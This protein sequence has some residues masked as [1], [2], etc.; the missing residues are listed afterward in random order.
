MPFFFGPKGREYVYHSDRPALYLVRRGTAPGT[1]DTALKEQ[2]LARGVEIRFKHK[3]ERL[4]RGGVV[5]HGPRRPNVISVGYVFETDTADGVFAALSDELAPKGYAYLL[6]HRGRGTVASCMFEDFHEEKVFVE[7][8]VEFF[9]RNVGFEMKASRRFGGLGNFYWVDTARH[10]TL[11][12]AGEAAG[13]QDALWGFGLRYAMVSGSLAARAAV[14]GAPETYDDLWERRFG[15]LL[16]ASA[17]NRFVYELM[18]SIGYGKLLRDLDRTSDVRA[19][20][21]RR[22]ALKAWKRVLAPLA[23]R[24]FRFDGGASCAEPSCDCTWCRY[25][26]SPPAGT[27]EGSPVAHAP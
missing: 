25:R 5:A 20:L 8:T 23:H 19:C 3:C 26:N 12:L 27:D 2:A 9:R 17:V 1:L 24:K 16:R 6:I 4:P 22:Y 14:A 7:R 18:G 11:L 21:R 13:F 15:R 10:G